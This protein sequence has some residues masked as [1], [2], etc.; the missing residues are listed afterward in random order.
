MTNILNMLNILKVFTTALVSLL[1]LQCSTPRSIEASYR[2]VAGSGKV[3][4]ENLNLKHDGSYIYNTS[5]LDHAAAPY[6]TEYRGSYA[7]NK[8]I[9][10]LTLDSTVTFRSDIDPQHPKET[11]S[12]DQH[13]TLVAVEP[14]QLTSFNRGDLLLK[15]SY[16]LQKSRSIMK[17]GIQEL[18]SRAE[19]PSTVK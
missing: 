8:K 5:I 15:P 6:Y 16:S 7:I 17:I 12:A 14:S 9:I 2:G 11:S 3:L 10:T 4:F 13:F 18:F 1:L 19:Y